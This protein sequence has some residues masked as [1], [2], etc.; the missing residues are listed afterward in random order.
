[1]SCCWSSAWL[2]HVKAKQQGEWCQNYL[3]RLTRA[4]I[5]AGKKSR[6]ICS[7]MAALKGGAIKKILANETPVNSQ[8]ASATG[9]AGLQSDL[10][11]ATTCRVKTI[12]TLVLWPSLKIVKTATDSL[13]NTFN[14]NNSGRN[15]L[16]SFN[17]A[18]FWCSIRTCNI[19]K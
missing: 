3:D 2:K 16:H 15:F 1:M 18:K 8:V 11:K 9:A 4:C 13:S 5:L 6:D 7:D 14:P 12:A 17:T 19:D 10:V